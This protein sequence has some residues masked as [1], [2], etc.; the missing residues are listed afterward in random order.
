[1]DQP[2][3][4]VMSVLGFHRR[5]SIIDLVGA[6]LLA[7]ACSVSPALSAPQ[8]AETI[9]GK[10]VE[11]FVKP[12][13]AAFH[14]ATGDLKSSLATLCATP[15]PANLD[16]ARDAFRKT[17]DAWSRAEIIRIGP[18]TE[19]NRLERVL[20]WPDR[21]GIGLRQV[22]AALAGQDSSVTDTA[23]LAGKSVAMQGLGALEFVLFGTDSDKLAAD[24][25]FRCAY[26]A[27]ISGNLDDIADTVAAGWTGT[28]GFG[29]IWAKPSADNPLY[30]DD[31]ESLTDLLEVFIN[32]LEL[33][34]DQ[35]VNSVL[36]AEAAED[37]PK[38]A[39]FWRSEGTAV[40]LAG[41]L[42]GMKAL[43][44]ASGLAGTLPES[45]GWIASSI[46]F[47]FGNAIHAAT[48]AQGPIGDVLADPTRRSKL[49]Y[50]KLVTTSLSELF[51]KRLSAELGLTAGFSSL[52]GD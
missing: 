7:F 27:A 13:Y 8:T 16:A 20:Y 28:T 11:N 12:A 17:T 18:I 44:D 6:A 21:K 32:G 14:D 29:A 23:T 43:F 30:R 41:N 35:R 24:D 52:D 48:G 5:R 39:L 4:S 3:A 15:S 37:K 50:F 9:I 22:Q 51:G 25:A 2:F 42:A 45:A 19:E 36:G 31:T 40:A 26:G 34:R 46:D 38:Q 33:V 1:M 47:E 10:S 49:S